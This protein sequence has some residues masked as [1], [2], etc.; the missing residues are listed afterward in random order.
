[1][2]PA[3]RKAWKRV[4][5]IGVVGVL[6]LVLGALAVGGG[7]PAANAP[8]KESNLYRF[9]LQDVCYHVL[10]SHRAPGEGSW[11]AT[12]I[13]LRLIDE[14]LRSAP[15]EREVGLRVRQIDMVELFDRVYFQT[16]DIGNTLTTSI[17]TADPTIEKFAVADVVYF[18]E[19]RSRLE[20]YKRDHDQSIQAERAR[21]AFSVDE[22][23]E[24]ICDHWAVYW[25]PPRAIVEL[26]DKALVDIDSGGKYDATVYQYKD[27]GRGRSLILQCPTAK[28]PVPS[29][30]FRW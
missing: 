24:L 13:R 18:L 5:V 15:P 7:E 30:S 6:P 27:E 14:D 20:S 26:R 12:L 9:E 4:R 16:G 10:M 1:M 17:K 23:W 19:L 29:R 2:S 22:V 8:A 25:A 3:F 28:G 21:T 11:L